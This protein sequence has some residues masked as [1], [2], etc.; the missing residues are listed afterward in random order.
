MEVVAAERIWQS[1]KENGF[2]YTTLVSDGDS[3]THTH[4]T[5][6][7]PYGELE[8]EKVECLNPVSYTHLNNLH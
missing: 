8:I 3:K 1:S 2:R 4:L 6:V 7:K 5:S